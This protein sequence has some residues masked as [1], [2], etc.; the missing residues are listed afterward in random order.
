MCG[1]FGITTKKDSGLESDLLKSTTEY[2]FKLSESRG[3]ESAGIASIF[4]G[5]INV[6]KRPLSASLLIK[7]KE[8]KEVFRQLVNKS[9]SNICLIAHARLITDG[10]SEINQ[11]NQPVIKDGIVSVHNGIIT[12]V[13]DLWEQFNNLKREYQVDTEVIL[14]LVRLFLSRGDSLDKSIKKVFGLIEGA[15]SV[16]FLFNDLNYLALTTNTG[17]LYF[18]TNQ[19]NS[20]VIFA[21][22]QY[23]LEKLVKKFNLGKILGQYQINQIKPGFGCLI[24]L[25]NLEKKEFSFDAEKFSNVKI[26][27]YSL[28]EINDLSPEDDVLLVKDEPSFNLSF[29][30]VINDEIYFKIDNLKR[31]TRCVLPETMPFIKFDQEGICNYCHGYKK[32]VVK[33]KEELKQTVLPYRNK[34]GRSDCIVTFSGGRDSSYG[35]YYIKDVLKMNPVAYSYDWGMLTD[36]AR[37]NQ[38]RICGKLGVEHILISAD[39]KRKREN[40]RKNV[41]AWLKKPNL[42]TVPLFM[43]GDKQFFYYANRLRKRTGTKLIL[44]CENPLEKTNFKFGFCGIKPRHDS[45]RIYAL[46]WVNKMRMAFYYGKQ[47]LLNPAY[48]NSSLPDTIGAY[49]SYYFIPHEYLFFYQYIKWDEEEIEE[50]LLGDYNWEMAKDA[51]TTWRIGD[52]TVAFYNY[53]YYLGTGFTENDTFRSN[54]I[55]EGVLSREKALKLVKRDNKP[56]YESIKWYCDTIGI[57]FEKTIK[58]INSMPRLYEKEQ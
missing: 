8:Y 6:F 2:L 20:V 34:S 58:K 27:N 5:K 11:N 1:I 22:E 18:Y 33:G 41:E 56:R 10:K 17:S 35:L 29:D 19:E 44:F 42:G 12:N 54:Q 24:N 16:A 40:I 21:S 38:A 49:I 13:D 53:I 50:T 37:R 25:D 14:S 23:I 55:R 48:F 4:N 31:C 15:A 47:F 9:D 36:L 30:L 52:G 45:K 7:E 3:K 51:K 46:S 43:A 39:I 32:M 28:F 57:D 26:N